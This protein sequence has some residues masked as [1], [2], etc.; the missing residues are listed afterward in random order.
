MEDITEGK[1]LRELK[2][3]DELKR[4]IDELHSNFEELAERIDTL[5]ILGIQD[6]LSSLHDSLLETQRDLAKLQI[7]V[8]H[9][10]SIIH[11]ETQSVLPQFVSELS[12]ALAKVHTS[13]VPLPIANEFVS[14][15]WEDLKKLGIN[16]IITVTL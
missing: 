11:E 12:A 15:R 5:E 8:T 3:I 2:D 14:K 13:E 16:P 6:Q 4:K 1:F 7:R 10:E 9:D